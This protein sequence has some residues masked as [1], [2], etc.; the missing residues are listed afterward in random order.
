LVKIRLPEVL[1]P[2]EEI[3]LVEEPVIESEINDDDDI[4]GFDDYLAKYQPAED[5]LDDV[6][7]V[8]TEVTTGLDKGIVETPEAVIPV[9]PVTLVAPVKS[10]IED[11]LDND[12]NETS[13]PEELET[14][15]DFWF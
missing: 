3:V 1:L 11:D 12:G 15:G 2:S 9:T 10:V 4:P 13:E 6:P 7:S 8:Q 14:A 5:V